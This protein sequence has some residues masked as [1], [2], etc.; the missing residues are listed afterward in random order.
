MKNETPLDYTHV[1]IQMAHWYNDPKV[2]K[3]PNQ[4]KAVNAAFEGKLRDIDEE[5]LSQLSEKFGGVIVKEIS[6]LVWQDTHNIIEN[7]WL[8]GNPELGE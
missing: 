2:I 1:S 6:K 3:T 7:E 8:R 4:E 5:K